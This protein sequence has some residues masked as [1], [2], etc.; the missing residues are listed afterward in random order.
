MGS[1]QQT[2]R[3]AEDRI[4]AHAAPGKGKPLAPF[5]YEPAPLG[6]HDVEVAISHCGVCH[7]DV[8]LVDNDWGVS[9][10]PL[11]PGHEII[12]TVSALG[13]GVPH[14]SRGQRVGIG[15][16]RGSCLSCHYCV[17]GREPLCDANQATC[18]GHYGG[19]ATHIRVDSRFAFPIPD[20]LDSATAA[21]LLCGGITVF[22]PLRD[23]AVTPQM[24]VGVV[25]VGGLGHLAIRFARAWGC[26]VTAFSSTP[27]KHD[28]ALQLGAHHFAASTD[29][30]A[31]K[32]AAGQD[33]I[34]STVM[35]DLD[36]GAYIDAL[37]PGGTLCVV[38]VPPSALKVEAFSLIG[39]Q[40][41]VC[42]SAIGGRAAMGEMLGFAARHAVGAQAECLPMAEANTALDRVRHNRARFRMVLTA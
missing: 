17:T 4:H 13:E 14:L 15:W 27:D 22:S 5:A 35:A 2:G 9:R 23:F 39:G 12:G 29:R 34:L 40:K 3:R 1:S 30:G 18:L 21:P 6:P 41:R 16:Q 31:V 36:W 24:R 42:G 25:G 37:A 19:F 38:G 26:E 7:S 33:F 10:Y 8:H 32:R 11:V 20:A 28:A